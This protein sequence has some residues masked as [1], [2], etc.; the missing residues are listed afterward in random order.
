MSDVYTTWTR[1]RESMGQLGAA[2]PGPVEGLALLQNAAFVDGDLPSKTKELIAVAVSV[3][4]PE[5]RLIPVHVHDAM[6]TGAT[7]QEIMEAVAVAILMGGATAAVRAT[8]V[9]DAID[10]FRD[11][12]TMARHA[13]MRAAAERAGL[14]HMFYGQDGDDAG[15]G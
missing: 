10:A 7:E 6:S 9:L 12:G 13:T 14:G 2:L 15:L 5:D 4:L 1:L 3:A 11:G 8:G